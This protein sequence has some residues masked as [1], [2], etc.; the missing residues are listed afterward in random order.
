MILGLRECDRLG[1]DSSYVPWKLRLQ[2]LMKE[3]DLW[4]NVV[5]EIS[6]PT[7]PTQ[8]VIHVKGI[9][10]NIIIHDL[11]KD[12]LISHIVEKTI[13]KLMFEDLIGLYQICRFC[14]HILLRN[15]L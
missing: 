1:R 11:M 6:E 3:A 14:R 12:C 8:L 10:E 2:L 15:K 7:N 13:G 4:E 9:K 5:K